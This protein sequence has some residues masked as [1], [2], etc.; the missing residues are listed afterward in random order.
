MASPLG[1]LAW[2][3]EEKGFLIQAEKGIYHFDIATSALN[4]ITAKLESSKVDTNYTYVLT[5]LSSD[6]V[7]FHTEQETLEYYLKVKQTL[8]E[9]KQYEPENQ[10]EQNKANKKEETIN[11]IKTKLEELTSELIDDL[12]NSMRRVADSLIDSF[13]NILKAIID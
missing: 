10:Q 7:Y 9:F 5:N 2:T 1:I 3:N 13:T 12:D 4:S 8:E 11:N 6:S